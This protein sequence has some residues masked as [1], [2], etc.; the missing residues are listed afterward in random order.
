[1]AGIGADSL[2]AVQNP[3]SPSGRLESF[4]VQDA[5]PR[6]PFPKPTA[7][8]DRGL[9]LTLHAIRRQLEAMPHDLFLIRLIHHASGR[10]FPGERLWTATQLLN[11]ATVK[12]LRIRNREGCDIYLHPYAENRNAGYILLDLDRVAP[13]VLK[14]MW[15]NGHEPCVVDSRQCAPT[16]TR[17]GHSDRQA[18]GL[19]VWRRFGQHRLAPPGKTGGVHQSEA[20]AAHAWGLRSLGESRVCPSWSGSQRRGFGAGGPA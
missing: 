11:S 1:M 2:G 5:F 7:G 10:A 13:S 3:G 12:F 17:C 15:A 19:C 6:Q 4:P 14:T 9:W 16:G 20:A 8:V 18:P